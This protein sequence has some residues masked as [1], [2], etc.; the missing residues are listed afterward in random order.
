MSLI[1]DFRSYLLED[2]LKIHL[3]KNKVN[4]INYIN[5]DHFDSNMILI[6]YS[7]GY[8]NIKGDKLIVTKLLNSELLIEGVI[9]S[10]ELK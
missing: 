9:R 5:I 3:Y 7:D 8:I 6:R 2:D 1:K 4:I 10:V